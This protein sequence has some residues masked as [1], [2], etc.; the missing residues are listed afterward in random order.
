MKRL[1]LHLQIAH[2][3][4]QLDKGYVKGE[5]RELW[6]HAGQNKEG[7]LGEVSSELSVKD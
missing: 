4:L 2:R 3:P 7:F 1:G 5:H 6:E